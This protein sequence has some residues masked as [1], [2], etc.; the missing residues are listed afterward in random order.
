M[1]A[2]I[3]TMVRYQRHSELKRRSRNSGIVK[4]LDFR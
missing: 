4:T 1:Y 3:E 2:M